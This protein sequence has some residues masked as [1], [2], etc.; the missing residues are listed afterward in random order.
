MENIL[1][2]FK[3]KGGRLHKGSR[4]GGVCEIYFRISDANDGR[5]ALSVVDKNGR[6]MPCFPAWAFRFNL[7]YYIQYCWRG[8]ICHLAALVQGQGPFQGRIIP[9]YANRNCRLDW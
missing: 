8:G 7:F 1:D 4:D 2:K 9:N 3:I 6:G 5:A